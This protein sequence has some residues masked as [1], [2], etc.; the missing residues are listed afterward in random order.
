MTASLLICVRDQLTFTRR[1]LEVLLEERSPLLAEVI[2]VDNGSTDGTG[3]FLGEL[4]ARESLVTVLSPGENLGFVGGNN[5]AAAHARGEY[6]VFLNNDTEPQPGWLEALVQTAEDDSTVGAVGAKLVYPD[7]RLQEAGSIVFAD[8][9]GWNVGKGGSVDDPRYRFVREVDYCSAACLLVRRALFEQ[10]GRFDERYAP[11]YYEDTDLCFGVRAL[12]YRVL[13]QPGA[14]IRHHEGGTAGTDLASG[15]KQHQVVNAERFREKWADELRLQSLPDASLVRRAANRAPGRR[16]VVVDPF[17]PM[18][19]RAS[20]SRRLHEML[21]LLA[22]QGHAVTFVACNSYERERYAPTLEQAGIEVHTGDRTGKPEVVA[23][24]L[25]SLLT[26]QDVDIVV[27]AFHYIARPLL[28]AVRESAPRARVVFDTVDVHFVREHREAELAGDETLRTSA[29]ETKRC[30]LAV[31]RETDATITVT[32]EDR[33]AILAEVPEATVYV[34]PNVHEAGGER[35]STLGRQGLLFVGNFNHPPN[36]DAALFLGHEVWPLV[37]RQVPEA[38]LT[39]VGPDPP[40]SVVQM[41]REITV[42]GWVERVEPYLERAR[43]S[44]APLRFGAGMKGKVGESLAAGL[45]VVTTA[46]GAEGIVAGDPESNGVLVGEDAGSLAAACVRLLQED[47]LWQRLSDAG[48]RVIGSRFGRAAV[49]AALEE[50]VTAEAAAR[51]EPGLTSIVIL[52]LGELELTRACIGSIA[53]H[54]PEPYELILVDNGSQ[55]GTPAYLEEL[56]QS[57]DDATVVLNLENRGFA[58]GCNQGLALARGDA[59]LFLN[60]DTQ[61]TPGWLGTLRR[62][63]EEDPEAGLVGPMSNHVSGGQLAP[64]VTYPD[65]IARFAS[66]W[67]ERRRGQV[68]EVTRLV[69]FCLLAR[70]TAL[71]LVGGYDERFASGNF[72]DDDLCLR[73]RA[74]GYRAYIA[75]EAYVH[76]EGSRTFAGQKIDY[77]QVM[78]RNWA[79]FKQLWQLPEGA[80]LEQGYEI[81]AE[82]RTTR[83]VALPNP[84]HAHSLAIGERVW[85]PDAVRA[86]AAPGGASA[87]SI[88]LAFREVLAWADDAKRY[89]ALRGLTATV[90]AQH[91]NNP[92][93]LMIAAEALTT[94]LEAEPAEPVLLNELGV[95]LYGLVEADG[96]EAAF[97]AAAA[98]DPALPSVHDNLA[99]CAELRR[100]RR[101]GKRHPRLGQ[102]AGRA[103][104]LA[105]RARPAAGQRL[106]L[107]MI[108]RDEEA[109]LGQCLEAAK[110]AADEIVVVDTGSTDSTVDIALAHGA[111]VI[112]TTWTGSFSEA[113]NISLEHATG[114]WILYLDADEILEPGSAAM[115][116]GLLTRTW[117]EAFY[118]TVRNL[119]NDSDAVSVDHEALRLFRNRP[120]TRFV[121]RIHEQHTQNMPLDRPERFERSDVLVIHHGYRPEVVAAKNKG[122]RN[123]EL[124][125]QEEET[126]FT[127]YNLGTELLSD[128]R[129]R[130]ALAML[131]RA[132]VEASTDVRRGF[133]RPQYFAPLALRIVQAHRLAAD[134]AGGLRRAEEAMELL[135]ELTDVVR[136]A[137]LCARASGDLDRAAAF[138]ERCLELGDAP[139]RLAGTAGAGSYLARALLASIR[140]EQGRFAEAHELLQRCLVE[141]PDYSEAEAALAEVRAKAALP[142]LRAA[143]RERSRGNL[144]VVL[145]GLPVTADT[146]VY[147][148]LATALAGGNPAALPIVCGEPAAALLDHLLEH[149]AFEAFEAALPV[150]N[151]VPLPER[152]RREALARIYLGRGFVDS[153]G[154]EW[155]AVAET[156][157]D[158]RAFI[159]LARVADAKGLTEDAYELASEALRLDPSSDEARMLRQALAA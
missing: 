153:A 98:L 6:L 142:A 52:T 71:D 94:A 57:R 100:A 155:M 99:S 30:E 14:V 28:A 63:L 140:T 73:V 2:V 86:V 59:V 119:T 121:G 102:I 34:V 54:T 129:P 78:L 127:L 21:L 123:R 50:L 82:R 69:G 26:E 88:G 145:A 105:R 150:W 42:T 126:A 60:N 120:E 74:A 5:L 132:W 85:R 116:R 118:L 37:R 20:G 109:M 125:E 1:C 56:A 151:A 141:R 147:R 143:A 108:V 8:G 77:A 135:P 79:V 75:H 124:L 22:A 111:T 128:E 97:R 104:K 15:F 93:I 152:E 19:D 159:G 27:L 144:E 107:C 81:D 115:I 41:D 101:S 51:C 10:L 122:V 89:S 83:Y 17:L 67:A 25:R 33:Q 23:K 32:E 84:G 43:V 80:P 95:L 156:D 45:P 113:R 149:Q 13:Y 29:A 49:S 11:A 16:L 114:D 70:R 40:A 53:E 64:D 47:A 48:P 76:H 130:E 158:S 9:T 12:G 138:A 7:G 133:P 146:A 134:P 68:T 103:Q 66:A 92:P 139:A 55:D 39:I 62:V 46:V 157:P 96:A 110:G 61:A 44:V 106:S 36:I 72:E 148:A 38:T 35:Q 87:S 137:A 91:T 65:G 117:R 136:E 3:E 90:F 4:A 18:F 24:L 58:G 31:V 154:E 131:E 112:E